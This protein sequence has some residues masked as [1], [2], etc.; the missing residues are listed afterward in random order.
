MSNKEIVEQFDALFVG[1]RDIYAVGYPAPNNPA[2]FRYELVEEQLTPKVLAKHLRGELCIGVYPILEDSTV[3]WFAIDFDAPKLPDGTEVDNPFDVAW[4]AATRQLSAFEQVGLHAY[5]E[6]SRSGKGVHVWGFLDG[7]LPAGVVRTAL[8]PLLTDHA[9]FT[10]RDRMYPVQDQLTE[11]KPCGNLIALPFFGEA[12]K[13]GNS[14]FLDTDGSPINPRTFLVMVRRNVPAIIEDLAAK[15]MEHRPVQ[16]TGEGRDYETAYRPEQPLVGALKMISNYGCKFM[17][18]CW[19]NRKV[20][21]EPLWYAALGQATCF[22]QG[23]EF[24]HA[25]SRDY[26]KYDPNETDA[27][28]NQALESPPVGCSWIQENYP[29]LVCE[30]CSCK[31]PYHVATK[32]VLDLV[33]GTSAEMEHVGEF[34]EDLTRIQKYDARTES[35]GLF[36]GIPGLDKYIRLRGSEITFIGGMQSSGKTWLMINGAYELADKQNIPVFMFSAETGRESLR[37]RLLSCASGVSLSALKG[38]RA[39]PLTS[40]E[41]LQLTTAAA[42]LEKLPIYTD[43]TSL[44][45]DDMLRQIETVLLRTK[46]PLSSPYVVFFDYLQF[47]LKKAGDDSEWARLSRLSGEFKFVTKILNRPLVVLSQLQREQEGGDK[48]NLT[49]YKGTGR[50]ESDADVAL[51]ITGERISSNLAPRM[52]WVVKQ[53][54]GI[55]NVAIPFLL[56]Q[57]C[58]VWTY[59]DQE[60]APIRPDLLGDLRPREGE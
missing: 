46:T 12:F 4:E 54:E 25:L 38:E 9:I 43:Y 57:S 1:R 44:S 47:G 48:P 51:I 17:K 58:G 21:P 6:R 60:A 7:V 59:T 32:S 27:K 56:D 24:A 50:I 18:H 11:K 14:A 52:I 20:L 55:S 49:W 39:T 41:W 16:R 15:N 22:E 5:L 34:T 36:W 2:K 23:R 13:L 35:S 53:R 42:R 37:Q 26:P 45:A 33:T 31:A 28:Y 10:S 3:G 30:N 19:D 40:A 8:K 29:E